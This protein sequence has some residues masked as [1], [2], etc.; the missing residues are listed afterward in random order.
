MV[1]V[2]EGRPQQFNCLQL[3]RYNY[4]SADSN[5]HAVLVCYGAQ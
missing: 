2:D 1:C 5:N 4:G 3:S